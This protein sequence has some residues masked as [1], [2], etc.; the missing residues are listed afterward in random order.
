M[1]ISYGE[2]EAENGAAGNAAFN[3]T[4]EQAAA[5]GVSV[6]VSAGDSG[7]GGCDDNEAAAFHGIAVSGFASTPYN[8]AVGGT[9]FGDSYAGTNS[10]YWR[11][12]NSSTYGSAKSYIPEIPWNNSCASV[13]VSNYVTGS[14]ITYGDSGFCN[15]FFAEIFGLV[16]TA[17][18][19]GGPSGC[20][21]GAPS[22]SGVVSG[23]CKGY[24]KPSWQ[25]LVG[26][27]GDG[28][29]DL[30]DVSLFASNGT[31]WGHFYIFCDSDAADG[32]AECTG[33]PDSWS[34]AG[35]TSFSSP[36]LA[37]IQ[38]LV[39]QKTGE[40]QGNPN[41]TYYKLAK[42]EYGASGSSSC[43]SSKGNGVASSCIFYDVTQG[44]MDVPCTGDHG[45][46]LPSGTYGVLSK[47]T[48]SYE[49]A[50]E[51]KTGYDHAT[52]IGSVNAYN[53]VFGW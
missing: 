18:G 49:N 4:Y 52:G 31:A 53:L 15:N 14:G 46:Y 36:I 11:S 20:A 43:N 44:D 42:T 38:S 6:F 26:V 22:K 3:S 28:V 30:P 40:R 8:V 1:S 17:G 33:A 19:S 12:S 10:T 51:A 47:S 13:L 48:T 39:N 29:R 27:P 25:S 16:T 23:T 21:T 41:P 24:A 5:E 45:C 50:F 2:C 32:G 7:A 37:A 9:D 34:A 35:G